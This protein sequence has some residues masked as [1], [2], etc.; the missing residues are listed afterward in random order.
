[1]KTTHE[2]T[3]GST[4]ADT[5]TTDVI[6]I[7]DEESICE[8]CRQALEA[9]GY[10]TATAPD[11]IQ[12]LQL[13]EKLQPKVILVDLRMPGMS[14]TELLAQVSQVAPTVVPIVITGHGSIDA[15]VETMKIGALDFITK[16]FTPEKLLG[17]VKRAMALREPEPVEA[18]PPAVPEAPPLNKQSALLQGLEAVGQF[19]SL[20][21]GKREFLDEFRRLESEAERHAEQI[22]HA[23]GKEEIVLEMV[24]DLQVVDRIIQQH[25]YSKSALIQVLLDVQMELNWLPRYCLRW[26]SVRLNIPQTEIYRVANFYEAFAL[27]RRGAHLIQ[28]CTGT[29]CHVRGAPRLLDRVSRVLGIGPGETDPEMKFTLQTVHCLGCCALGPVMVVDDKYHSNPSTKQLEKI[30]EACN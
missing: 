9:D 11:G 8:G 16:P 15:A 28:V 20:G 23:K 10:G 6:V 7:D 26:I 22:G 5:G 27:E 29:A 3:A 12:G 1:M 2:S 17:S 14:G 24:H 13:V 19:C 25:E 18:A 21:F 30:A 4:F